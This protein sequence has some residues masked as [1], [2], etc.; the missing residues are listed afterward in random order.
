MKF[1]LRRLIFKWLSFIK[2]YMVNHSFIYNHFFYSIFST[3]GRRMHAVI[4]SKTYFR[5]LPAELWTS[6]LIQV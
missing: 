4:Y 6:Q 3:L 1:G 2:L 5:K